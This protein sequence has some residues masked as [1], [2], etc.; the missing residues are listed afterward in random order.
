[1]LAS[2]ASKRPQRYGDSKAVTLDRG[3]DLPSV[4]T[5]TNLT[6]SAQRARL[7]GKHNKR[8]KGKDNA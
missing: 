1:M 5:S 3:R 8:A 2:V 7:S 4:V 6:N